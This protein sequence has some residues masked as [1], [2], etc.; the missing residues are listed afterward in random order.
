MLNEFDLYI[1]YSFSEGFC[2]AVLEA[3]SRGM[4][5][6]VSDAGAFSE[7]IINNKTGW[8][9]PKNNPTLL[10]KKIAEVISLSE[11]KKHKIKKQ[12][13]KRVAKEYNI[14]KQQKEFID[15]YNF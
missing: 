12:A 3:Q 15:F 2:N 1:Q 9:V 5:S 10:A 8:V 14:E 4:L 6:I 11:I 7:N 13:I